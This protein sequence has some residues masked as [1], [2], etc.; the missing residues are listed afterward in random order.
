MKYFACVVQCEGEVAGSQAGLCC[1]AA[2]MQLSICIQANFNFY[3][4]VSSRVEWSATVP[5]PATSAATLVVTLFC[6][7]DTFGLGI[8]SKILLRYLISSVP[9]GGM[10][11]NK[12]EATILLLW[13]RTCHCGQCVCHSLTDIGSQSK[14]IE[15]EVL[16]LF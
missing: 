7:G 8:K 16:L 4:F 6:Q 9:T 14:P 15:V 3:H 10:K 13:G 2:T 1:P 5:G 11:G 12:L